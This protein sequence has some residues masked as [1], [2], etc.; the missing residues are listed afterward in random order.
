[1]ILHALEIMEYIFNSPRS[2]IL[3][4]NSLVLATMKLRLP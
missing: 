4:F 2:D 1:M 3:V